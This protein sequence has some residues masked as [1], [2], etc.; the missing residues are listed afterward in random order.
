MF[1]INVNV[2]LKSKFVL[3][4]LIKFVVDIRKELWAVLAKLLEFKESIL[5]T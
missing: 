4:K 1:D 5:L 2:L 3:D